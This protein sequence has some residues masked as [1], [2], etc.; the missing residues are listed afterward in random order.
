[1]AGF[2][3]RSLSIRNTKTKSVKPAGSSGSD[4]WP[5]NNTNEMPISEPY[6]RVH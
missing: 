1:M 2:L 6:A 4:N 3:P 5:S